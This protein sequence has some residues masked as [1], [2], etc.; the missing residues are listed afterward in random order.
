MSDC[1]FFFLT[2]N[3]VE[4]AKDLYLFGLFHELDFWYIY[5]VQPEYKLIILKL[6]IIAVSCGKVSAPGWFQVTSLMLCRFFFKI[7][8]DNLRY[9]QVHPTFNFSKDQSW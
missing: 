9:K 3:R 4:N 1:V 8:K 6:N 5:N 7:F 2:T